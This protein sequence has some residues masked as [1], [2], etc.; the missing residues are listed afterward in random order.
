MKSILEEVNGLVNETKG[1]TEVDNTNVEQPEV[2]NT[3]V[4]QPN[5]QKMTVVDLK[6][7]LR[8]RGLKISGKKAMLIERLQ[9]DDA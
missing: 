6:G 5:Y 4:E 1:E 2:D 8:T 7:I 3:N 9:E